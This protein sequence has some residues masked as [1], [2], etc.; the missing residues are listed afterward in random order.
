MNVVRNTWADKRKG[1]S[2]TVTITVETTR[3]AAGAEF[4]LMAEL[5]AVVE[6]YIDPAGLADDAG[7]QP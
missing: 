6:R 3:P 5:S 2:R 4:D 1:R 7:E